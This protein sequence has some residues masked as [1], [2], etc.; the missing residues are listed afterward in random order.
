MKK[1]ILASLSLFFISSLALAENLSFETCDKTPTSIPRN[2]V[3]IHFLSIA[4][5]AKE[6]DTYVKALSLQKTGLSDRSDITGVRATSQFNRSFL[7]RV[8]NNDQVRVRFM[9]PVF[10]KKGSTEVFEITAHLDSKV[11]RTIGFKL[12]NIESSDGINASRP[13]ISMPQNTTSKKQQTPTRRISNFQTQSLSFKPLGTNNARLRFGRD[14]RIGRFRIQNN[15]KKRVT[16]Q[17]LILENKGTARLNETFNQLELRNSQ[18]VTIAVSNQLTGKDAAF[19][20]N[21]ISFSGGEGLTLDVWGNVTGGRTGRTINLVLDEA[22]DLKAFLP[23]SGSSTRTSQSA[24]PTKTLTQNT[25]SYE[26]PKISRGSTSFLWNQNYTAG[27]KDVIFLSENIRNKAPILIEDVLVFVSN[28]SIASDKNNNGQSN[29]LY[30]FER[31]FEEMS[32]YID[33]RLQD[34]VNE[35]ESIGNG[36]FVLRFRGDF[37]LSNTMNFMVTGKVSRE[38]INGD[39]LRLTINPQKSFP[40]WERL[41]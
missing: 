31:T 39:R 21:E 2:G 14:A 34:Q 3:N 4:I 38:A 6:N 37:E 25:L 1:T 36:Q 24:T 18:G 10:I 41:R 33:G 19:I 35:F 32:L 15:G 30:D 9:K 20:F 17:S 12:I 40:D 11:G 8:D 13:T 7:G 23:N 5:T 29:E 28:G 27:S 22:D 16:L 26:T